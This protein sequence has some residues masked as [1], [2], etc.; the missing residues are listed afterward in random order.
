MHSSDPFPV[1]LLTAREV[2][3][4]LNVS[5]VTV[6][7]LIRLRYLGVVRIGRSVRI[8][9][10]ELKRYMSENTRPAL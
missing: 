5:E 7:R 3:S 2:A 6:R 9:P 1:E 10:D 4:R 8:T